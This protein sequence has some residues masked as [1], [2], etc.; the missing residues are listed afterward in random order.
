L[1]KVT[2]FA[3]LSG[4]GVASA[5]TV[6]DY[7]K[8]MHDLDEDKRYAAI[9]VLKTYPP[10]EAVVTALLEAL[11]DKATGPRFAAAFVLGQ[12][13]ADP[14]RVVPALIRALDDATN[15]STAAAALGNFGEDAAPALSKLASL[16]TDP[17]ETVRRNAIEGLGGFAAG[18]AAAQELIVGRLQDPAPYVRNKA[19]SALSYLGASSRNYLP[20]FITALA[21]PA[22]QV[23]TVAAQAIRPF[24]A[25][26][27]PALPALVAASRTSTEALSSLR[28][29]IVEISM[30]QAVS[31]VPLLIEALNDAANSLNGRAFAAATLGDMGLQG[32]VAIPDLLKASKESP[33]FVRNAAADALAKLNPETTAQTGDL[34]RLIA[35]LASD[36]ERS[37]DRAK[38]TLKK[39]GADAIPLLLDVIRKDMRDKVRAAAVQT[40]GE[41]HDPENTAVSVLTDLIANADSTEVQKAVINALGHLDPG[42]PA[43]EAITRALRNLKA[44]QTALW[45]LGNLRAASAVPAIKE[46]LEQALKSG[47]EETILSSLKALGQIGPPAQMAVSLTIPLLDHANPAISHAATNALGGM[48]VSEAVAALVK[49]LHH[50]SDWKREEAAQSIGRILSRSDQSTFTADAVTVLIEHRKDP[51]PTV[52]AAVVAAL[53][54]SGTAKAAR[55]VI[56]AISDSHFHVRWAAAGALIALFKDPGDVWIKEAALP[57]LI[58]ALDDPDSRVAFDSAQ[59]LQA[60]GPVCAPALPAI[61]RALSIAEGTKALLI[62]DAI[63]AIEGKPVH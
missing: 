42:M 62:R 52:R 12:L 24:G 49:M 58:Q 59:A 37:Q 63:S 11:N 60:C 23:R 34:S 54:Q 40:L 38:S 10:T 47:D 2:I 9:I 16:M 15:R 3:A 43:I 21:D 51:T 45:A 22:Q 14:P 20:Q 25:A 4:L 19:I 56:E 41:I 26:G 57:G 30:K 35:M 44:R 32:Q 13:R 28:L 17:D 31:P 1:L 46:T 27:A 61:R 50:T 33:E 18:S 29:A 55:P 6:E 5:Q 53:G 7:L 48:P 39:A 36:D 8:Q